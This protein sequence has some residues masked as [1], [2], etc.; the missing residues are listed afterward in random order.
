MAIGSV[1]QIIMK[2]NLTKRFLTCVSNGFWKLYSR[3]TS[4][5]LKIFHGQTI[6]YWGHM[7]GMI[8]EVYIYM[9]SICIYIYTYI[10]IKNWADHATIPYQCKFENGLLDNSVRIRQLQYTPAGIWNK[11]EER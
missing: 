9:Y 4:G 8:I 3:Y 6:V 10:D 5:I 11:L 7:K 1:S 2:V